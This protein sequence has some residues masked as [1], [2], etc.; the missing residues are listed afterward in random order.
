M[1]SSTGNLTSVVNLRNVLDLLVR[2]RQGVRNGMNRKKKE[3]DQKNHIQLVCFPL[4][5]GFIP[6]LDPYRFRRQ[7]RA[8]RGLG[9]RVAAQESGGLQ[10]PK[11]RGVARGADRAAAANGGD[12]GNWSDGVS[13]GNG[14]DLPRQ[15]I[16]GG[17][18]GETDVR[19]SKHPFSLGPEMA[20]RCFLME[21]TPKTGFGQT[22]CR[23][24]ERKCAMRDKR[25]FWVWH[26]TK[27]TSFAL[28]VILGWISFRRVLTM[29]PTAS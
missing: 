22:D 19:G 28:N 15:R 21:D 29:F 4:R 23:G 18:S 13:G 11:R 1:S 14:Q 17:F 2:N 27:I 12:P 6:F 20:K 5:D 16:S 26:V 25:G 8:L 3:R 9:G 7:R 24:E 10:P